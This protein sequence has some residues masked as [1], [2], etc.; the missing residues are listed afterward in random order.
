MRQQEIAFDRDEV[1]EIFARFGFEKDKTILGTLDH[2]E[3]KFQPVPGIPLRSVVI[4]AKPDS[5]QIALR[6][7]MGGHTAMEHE[8]AAGPE[9]FSLYLAS[10][11]GERYEASVTQDSLVGRCREEATSKVLAVYPFERMKHA[12]LCRGFQVAL[13]KGVDIDYLVDPT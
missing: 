9:A 12:N 2:W 4:T 5:Y 11:I 10:V 13:E 3:R 8:N 6:P 7:T 1:A